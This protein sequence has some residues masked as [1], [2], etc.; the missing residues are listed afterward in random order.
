MKWDYE[1]LMREALRIEEQPSEELDQK[2]MEK[3][4]ER[5]SMKKR[6]WNG[7]KTAVAVAAL[8]AILLGGTA[9][10]NAAT[11]GAVEKA[12]N[13]FFES[14]VYSS[15]EDKNF[16]FYQ[17]KD[18]NNVVQ[19]GEFHDMDIEDISDET[20]SQEEKELAKDNYGT[21]IIFEQDDENSPERIHYETNSDKQHAIFNLKIGEDTQ[22]I[23]TDFEDWMD[24][25]DKTWQLRQ[26]F[27][28]SAVKEN[29]QGYIK[30]LQKIKDK[31]KEDYVKQ[32]IT[33]SISDL[34]SDKTIYISRY[35]VPASVLDKDAK[36]TDEIADAAWIKI[37]H[38]D[39]T[40]KDD[41][42]EIV[43]DSVAGYKIKCKC[44][45]KKNDEGDYQIDKI[46]AVK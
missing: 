21:G 39:L 32:A 42:S 18:G 9:T 25:E 6:N 16:I 35:D 29:L 11:D 7:K 43:C 17:D 3:F 15:D 30:E 36:K 28:E 2:L 26:T 8:C 22:M 37:N 38:D 23:S 13:K 5:D 45:I 44:T 10:V 20:L 4:K 27:N 1:E 46:E 12:I 40:F 14:V 24:D 41:K 34:K 31:S 19:S 33:Q